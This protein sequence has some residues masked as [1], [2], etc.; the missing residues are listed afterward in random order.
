MTLGGQGSYTVTEEE[1]FHVPADVV[2]V[3]DSSGAG[4]CFL[5]ALAFFLGCRSL[6]LRD[7][8]AR[9]THIASMSVQHPGT[10]ASYPDRHLL[11]PHM[12]DA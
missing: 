9:A 4:D 8:V 6:R 11:P 5:G 12:L 1:A 10:Q 3:V 2:R 7:S